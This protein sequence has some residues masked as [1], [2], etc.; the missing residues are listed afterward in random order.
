MKTKRNNKQSWRGRLEA[1]GLGLFI[2]TAVINLGAGQPAAAPSMNWTEIEIHESER[3]PVRAWAAICFDA[4]RQVIVLHGGRYNHPN[5]Y[6]ESLSD[7]WEF[8]GLSWEQASTDGPTR[9]GARMAFDENRCVCVLYSGYEIRNGDWRAYSDTW[10][11]DGAEWIQ[12]GNVSSEPGHTHG[13]AYDPLR[14]KVVR[15]GGGT[16]SDPTLYSKTYEWDGVDW[17]EISAAGP[18]GYAGLFFEPARQKLMTYTAVFTPDSGY[19]GQLWEL[20]G[21]HWI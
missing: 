14:Q 20:D 5:G 12:A 18:P 2:M 8:D 10:E 13:M 16:P 3:P 11:W 4:I 19:H 6:Q 9:T 7:T 15:H 17:T 1:V 21:N